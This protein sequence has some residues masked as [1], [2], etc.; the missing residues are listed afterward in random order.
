MSPGSVILDLAPENGTYG[1][2]MIGDQQFQPSAFDLWM[3]LRIMEWRGHW[4]AWQALSPVKR[5]RL[6]HTWHHTPLA[7]VLFAPS[8]PRGR[9]GKRSYIETVEQWRA[10]LIPLILK[11]DRPGDPLTVVRLAPY[12]HDVLPRRSHVQAN[13]QGA[14]VERYIRKKEKHFKLTLKAL[15]QEVRSKQKIF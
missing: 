3:F 14:S 9:G 4:P 1:T 12:L 7:R 11:L 2:L 10:L 6:E 15:I 5:G 8:A 13:R